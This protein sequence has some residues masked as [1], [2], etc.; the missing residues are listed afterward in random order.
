MK[1]AQLGYT[2]PKS[3]STKIGSD[4]I[5]FYVEGTNLFTLSGL[6]AGIDPE[7]PGVTNGY[8]P[9]QRTIMGGLTISF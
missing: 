7:R 5:R 1:S 8:Y 3:I 9:Q 6:P 2:L 4:N